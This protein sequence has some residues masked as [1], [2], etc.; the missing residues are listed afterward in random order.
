MERSLVKVK[1][2]KLITTSRLIAMKFEKEHFDVL[3]AIRN[4]ECSDEFRERN[5]AFIESQGV[6]WSPVIKN[7]YYEITRDGFSFLVMG[8]TGK[9]AAKF[10]EEFIHAFNQMEERIKNQSI[11]LPQ[12]YISALK[13]LIVSEEAK[14]IAE[15]KVKE[16][17]PKAE[18]YDKISDAEN[19]LTL[20]DVAKTIGIG[21]NRMMK[22]LRELKVLRTDNTP[23]QEFIEA[24]YFKTKVRPLVMGDTITDYI[25]T[26]VP[27]KEM[28]WLTKKFTM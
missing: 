23:Y 16:L 13:A 2:G 28:T 25:Q 14:I 22:Q 3:K 20:N 26:F 12:D 21:R 19:L 6:A 7:N 5:F 9:L 24:G 1:D 15:D 18:V 8:F 10:K 11:Q 4:L 27:G 17:S